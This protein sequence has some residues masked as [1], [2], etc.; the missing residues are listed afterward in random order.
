MTRF[1]WFG[2][3][4]CA[5]LFAFVLCPAAW[6]LGYP[7]PQEKPCQTY[8]DSA[9]SHRLAKHHPAV[10]SYIAD[11]H[12]VIAILKDGS[13]IMDTHDAK[14]CRVL[15]MLSKSQVRDFLHWMKPGR[16]A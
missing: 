12:M 15:H 8:W 1:H 10:V 14:G 9:R 5:G 7:I 6:A 11:P 13:G 16:N 3:V 4:L 2:L